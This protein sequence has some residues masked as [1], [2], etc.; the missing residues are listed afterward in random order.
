[1]LDKRAVWRYNRYINYEGN[2]HMKKSLMIKAIALALAA[3]VSVGAL[4]GCT[5]PGER[6][7][8]SDTDSI[9]VLGKNTTLPEGLTVFSDSGETADITP[10]MWKVTSPEGSSVYLFGTIHALTPDCYPLPVAIKN[11]YDECDKLAVE[12]IT[13]DSSL[14]I[15]D[16]A[17][18]PQVNHLLNEGD[19]LKNH[20]TAEQYSLLIDYLATYD[21]DIADY[22]TFTPW[23]V[24]R[25]LFANGTTDINTVDSSISATYGIDRIL[26]ITANIDEKEVLAMENDPSR[27]ALFSTMPEDVIGAAIEQGCNKGDE[28]A[29][30]SMIDSLNAWKTGDLEE[31]ER[32]AYDT[33]GVIEEHVP[34]IEKFNYY[35]VTARNKVMAAKIKEYLADGGKVFVTAGA[36]HFA[37][38]EGIPALLEQDG[39]T[40][41]KIM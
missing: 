13:Q 8:S 34:L 18:D 3:A 14:A 19:S 17:G 9:Y 5:P 30:Q 35:F 12:V 28:G 40:V 23:L 37:G 4:T 25:V 6:N 7:N 33:S 10:A 32:I 36:A 26:E 11:A 22:D 15:T 27:V 21:L 41:E 2:D 16:D 38:D 1:M 24:F 31:L 29:A 20:L 39:Y